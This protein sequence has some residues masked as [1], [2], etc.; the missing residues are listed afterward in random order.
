MLGK[1]RADTDRDTTIW[2]GGLEDEEGYE[3]THVATTRINA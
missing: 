3:R 1:E 2:S